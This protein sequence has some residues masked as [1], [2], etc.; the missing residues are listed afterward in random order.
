MYLLLNPT[1]CAPQYG[2][3]C[4]YAMSRDYIADITLMAWRVVDGKFYLNNSKAV[5]L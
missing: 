4:S 5:H 2:G 1:S 3:Y